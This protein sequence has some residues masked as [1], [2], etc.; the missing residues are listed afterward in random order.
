MCS[1][2]REENGYPPRSHDCQPVETEFTQSF[3]ESQEDLK[4]QEA[5]AKK[6]RTMAMWKNALVHTWYTRPM[7]STQKLIDR[8]PKIMK[9]IID[10]G[11]ERTKY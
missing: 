7:K 10:N 9:E 8:M 5:N 3:S 2:D 11:G 6:K 1:E 4:R